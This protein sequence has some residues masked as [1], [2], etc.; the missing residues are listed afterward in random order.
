[1]DKLRISCVLA[2]LLAAGPYPAA[3]Q[4]A[5]ELKPDAGEETAA[6]IS[7]SPV[8]EAEWE[9]IRTAALD[10][11]EDVLE[12]VLPQLGDWLVRNPAHRHSHEAQL[13]KAKLTHA[14]GESKAALVDL[15]KHFQVYPG[16]PSSVE[17]RK[18]FD[19]LTKKADKEFKPALDLMATEPGTP[20][21]DLNLSSLLEALALKGG[22]E[23]Y[24]PL[25]AEYRAFF[26]RFPEYSRN[27]MV[28]LSLA[29]LHRQKGEY[30]AARLG[31]EK[32]I[33]LH[34]ASPLLAGAKFSLGGVLADNLKEY[35]R[36]IEVFQD[37][38]ASFPGTDEAWNSYNRLPVLAEKQKKY[39]LAVEIDEKIIALYPETPEAYSAYLG[40]AR[41]LRE[42]LKKYAEAIAVLNRLADKYKD[43]R[44]VD[45]LLLA[46]DIY[47]KDLKDTAGEIKM[48]DRIADEFPKN[49]QAPKALYAAGE[50]H[51]K[52]KDMDNARRYFDRVML[53]YPDDAISKKAV[54]RVSDIVAG[55]L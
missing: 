31:Y 34:P 15:L 20:A 11:K 6:V 43:G 54:S 14:L 30:L 19:A 47:R 22:K 3:A 50:I 18:L 29:A 52:A 9:F 49:E 36:A 24:A 41:L 7:P 33:R 27:D 12:M 17:A 1:M 25:V 40:E 55:K 8:T 38:A 39:D 35:D 23:Y 44:A 48:Y 46:S 26:N 13:L 45:A 5:A 16:A 53:N 37:I 51:F 32:M 28:R 42:K 4:Q 10:K 2:A 21:V